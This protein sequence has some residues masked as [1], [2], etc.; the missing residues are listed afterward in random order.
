MGTDINLQNS[1]LNHEVDA[2]VSC[3]L[4]EAPPEIK[5][6]VFKNKEGETV[7]DGEEKLCEIPSVEK[8]GDFVMR[9]K[10]WE[11]CVKYYRAR[12]KYTTAKANGGVKYQRAVEEHKKRC[13][14]KKV[15]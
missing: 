3:S 4:P 7:D 5:K 11:A 14:H 12:D 6:Y 2:E 1:L 8:Q 13:V 9:D 15:S 10:A